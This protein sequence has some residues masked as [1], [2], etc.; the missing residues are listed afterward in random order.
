MRLFIV[1]IRDSAS[2]AYHAPLFFPALGLA[3][4]WFRDECN[5]QQS[6]LFKH[7]ADY[8][9]YVLG[10]YETDTGELSP[11]T[12]RLIARGQDMK[13]ALAS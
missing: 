1:T 11:D 6:D 12:P 9:L 7:P 8:E 5:S 4:R 3:E 10:S 2:A 13:P